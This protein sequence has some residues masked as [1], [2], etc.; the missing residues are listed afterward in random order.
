VNYRLTPGI[1]TN[2]AARVRALL[3][4]TDDA[5]NAIRF[6]KVNAAMYGIDPT[7]VAVFGSSAGGTVALVNAVEF[8]TL[9][10]AVSDYAGVSAKV[11]AAVATGATLVDANLSVDA[12]VHYDATDTPVLLYHANPTD[13]VSGVTWNS[14]VLPTKARIDGSG[15]SC[16]LVAQPDRS[17]VVDLS[18]GGPYWPATRSFLWSRLRLSEMR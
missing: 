4:A 8:D 17:H 10:G 15:N 7:R 5:M 1:E 18:L 3:H 14:G 13:G 12:Y 2:F 16:T 9:S 6:L 11:Q